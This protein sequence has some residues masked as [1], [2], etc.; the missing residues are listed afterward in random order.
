MLLKNYIRIKVR[1]LAPLIQSIVGV[2]SEEIVLEKGTKLGDLLEELVC[3][4]NG[5]LA[6][7]LFSENGKLNQG[8]LIMVNGSIAHNLDMVLNDMDEIVLT[9]PFN[10]G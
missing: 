8:I 1:Y 4:H 2:E 3:V 5:E 7:W 6:K 10:G 9:I